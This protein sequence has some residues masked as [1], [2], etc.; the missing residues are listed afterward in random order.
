MDK[1]SGSPA[2][3][4]TFEFAGQLFKIWFQYPK[5]DGKRE[6]V[7]LIDRV[8]EDKTF[9]AG[10]SVCAASDQFCKETGRKIALTRALRCL[11]LLEKP[12]GA[13]THVWVSRTPEPAKL[14][15]TAAWAAYRARRYGTLEVAQNKTQNA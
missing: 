2:K 5:H 4:L 9:A 15:R 3:P 7:C 14:F 1:T 6:C 11:Q 10:S 13:Q 8:G 12:A